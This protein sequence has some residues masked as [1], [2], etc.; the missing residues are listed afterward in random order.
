MIQFTQVS[1]A[2]GKQ[3]VLNNISF[4]INPGERVGVVGP[5]GTGKS[6]LFEMLSGNLSPDKGEIAVKNNHFR[7]FHVKQRK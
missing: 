1:K 2:F 6:T 3:Q 7:L 4:T 5:N